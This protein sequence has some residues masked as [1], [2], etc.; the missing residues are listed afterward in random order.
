MT[1]REISVREI[2]V[3]H[4]VSFSIGAAA[5]LYVAPTFAPATPAVP[6]IVAHIPA[7]TPP[8]TEQLQE[9]RQRLPGQFG[10]DPKL[11]PDFQPHRLLKLL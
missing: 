7:D 4:I 3:R 6:P 11:P 10:D 9:L 2:V 8:I 1:T 5:A